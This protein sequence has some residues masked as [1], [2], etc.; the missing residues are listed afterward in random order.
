MK[1]IFFLIFLC[2][3]FSCSN[4]NSD[5]GTPE[6]VFW[7]KVTKAPYIE[8]PKKDLP[9]WVLIKINEIETLPL[10]SSQKTQIF[11]CEWKN[12]PVYFIL[13]PLL[14]CLF[15]EAYHKDGTRIEW[16]SQSELDNFLRASKNWVIIYEFEYN[17]I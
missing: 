9:G 1:N 14:S 12:R 2:V 7:R 4:N 11:V 10:P 13:G 15:C 5:L 3:T 17:P 8:V 6:E 16:T